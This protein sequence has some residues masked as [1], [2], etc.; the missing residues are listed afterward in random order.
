M[1]AVPAAAVA[2]VV[3]QCAQKGVMGLVV[4]SAGFGEVGSAGATAQHEL[5]ALAR[6]K[7]MRLVGPNASASPTPR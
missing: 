1:I 7:G 6:R 3:D 4:L 2:G 5:W